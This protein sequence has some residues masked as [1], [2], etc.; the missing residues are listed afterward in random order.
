MN[1]PA[2]AQ[3]ALA[4]ARALIA[5][6]DSAGMVRGKDY[7]Y[8]EVPGGEYNETAWQARVEPLLKAAYPPAPATQPSASGQ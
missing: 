4:N 8:E 7:V 1:D 5:A 6:F 2:V 3:A